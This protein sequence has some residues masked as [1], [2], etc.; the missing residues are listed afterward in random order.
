MHPL[1]DLSAYL[2]GEL[3]GG[4]RAAVESHL[5]A[6]DSCRGRLAPL[7]ATARLIAA[8]PS[9]VPARSLVPRV[10]VPVW[11][12]PRSTRPSCERTAER[13]R[14]PRSPSALP[15]VLRGRRRR[16]CGSR[17]RSRW[18][19]WLSCCTGGYEAPRGGYS[20]V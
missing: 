11:L 20:M 8:L 19:P 3:D 10:A 9:P 12:Q 17:S 4:R 16:S 15:S 18:R 14:R 7:R 1:E 13:P 5:A 6:C 2:D